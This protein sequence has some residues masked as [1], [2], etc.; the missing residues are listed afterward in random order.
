MTSAPAKT[1]MI[2]TPQRAKTSNLPVPATYLVTLG[3]T[4][5]ANAALLFFNQIQPINKTTIALIFLLPV[6]LS[7]TLGGLVPGILAA[8]T[9]FLAFN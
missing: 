9:A 6:G 1:T 5:A 8:V 2:P 4:F 3:V 7:A